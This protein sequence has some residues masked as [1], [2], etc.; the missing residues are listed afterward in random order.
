M[1]RAKRAGVARIS[2]MTGKLRK[3]MRS[4]ALPRILEG[5]AIGVALWCILFAFELLPGE[6]ADTAGVLLFGLAG[7][8]IGVTRFH[9]GLSVILALAAAVV[10]VVTQ[11]SVSNVVASKWIRNDQFPD[12]AVQAVVVLSAALNPNGT[13]SSEALDHLITGIELV[14]VGKGDVLVT[15]T[16]ER[17]FHTGLVTSALDQSRIVAL[18]GVQARWIRTP[19]VN[20]TR[21]EALRS[22][23]LLLPRGIQRIAVVAA[24]MHTR[25][26]CSAFEAVGFDVICVPGRARSPGGGDPGPWPADRL[27]VFGEWVYEV[28]G[29]TKYRANGWLRSPP[30]ANKLARHSRTRPRA[31][32][33]G[34]GDRSRP[35]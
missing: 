34:W 15:T 18:A 4:F 14:R 30:L 2:V 10:V 6:A 23:E 27:N 1:S 8:V 9:R 12:S 19:P 35:K 29:M 13:I 17:P 21:D 33:V 24:P 31:P 5:G 22:A 7:L 32:A 3:L 16:V 28:V 25:R 20:S 11:T 26:A